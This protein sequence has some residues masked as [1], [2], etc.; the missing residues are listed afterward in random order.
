MQLTDWPFSIYVT[1]LI[2]EWLKGLGGLDEMA[3]INERKAKLIYD[4]IDH[5][6]Q[7]F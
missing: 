6:N 4:V 1:N 2:L 5:S 7:F 3:K